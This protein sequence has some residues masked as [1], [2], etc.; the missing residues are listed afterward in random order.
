[1]TKQELHRDAAERYLAQLRYELRHARRGDREDYLAQIAEHINESR[2][3]FDPVDTKALDEL[4][5][6]LGSPSSLAKG[7][8]VTERS[9]LNVVWRML[10]WLRR[11]WI[12]VSTVTVVAIVVTF[13]VWLSTYQP[14]S[15]NLNGEYQDSVVALSGT[16]PVK[17]SEGAVQPVTWKL[18][19]GRYRVSILFAATNTN[20][21]P[22]TISP[23]QFVPGFPNSVSWQLESNR[24]TRKWPFV[25]ARVPGHW[26]REIVATTTYTCRPWPT[27]NP[28]A[29]GD[30]TMYINN[31]PI[32]TSFWG[33]QHSLRLAVQPFYLEFA[34]KCFGN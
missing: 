15:L 23:P 32:V 17:L 1:M 18:T 19:D 25:S 29:A 16:A 26:Y 31:F 28:N 24:S 5:G 22:V 8:Y 11:W 7:F 6:R 27:G 4:L 12:V 9:K 20:S 21:L 3:L 34:G 30:Q 10:Q 2:S 14:L 33:H 13:E